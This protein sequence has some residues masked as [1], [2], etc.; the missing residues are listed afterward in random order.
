MYVVATMSEL[1]QSRNAAPC[2]PGPLFLAKPT[3]APD[4]ELQAVAAFASFI[5]R[6]PLE[7]G[8]LEREGAFR[9][10]HL[11]FPQLFDIDQVRPNLDC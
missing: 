11:H 5:R 2:A 1:G 7:A 9:Q 6:G 4:R 3:L 8:R 10:S